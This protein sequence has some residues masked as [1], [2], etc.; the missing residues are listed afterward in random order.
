MVTKGNLRVRSTNMKESTMD[1]RLKMVAERI[2]CRNIIEKKGKF[3]RISG[4]ELSLRRDNSGKILL[5]KGM[6]DKSK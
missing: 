2:Y 3:R 5:Q 6:T 4:K 1:E